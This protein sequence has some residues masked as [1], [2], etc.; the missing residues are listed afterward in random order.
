MY[1]FKPFPWNSAA[2]MDTVGCGRRGCVSFTRLDGAAGPLV[3]VKTLPKARSDTSDVRNREIIVREIS[4]W[5]RASGRPHVCSLFDVL[6]DSAC[7]YLVLEACRG[8]DLAGASLDLVRGRPDG[9]RVAVRQTAMGLAACHAADIFH[10]DVKPANVLLKID[11]REGLYVKLG[12][13][14]ASRAVGNSRDQGAVAEATPAYAA[15][16]IAAGT[17]SAY[18][19]EGLAADVWALGV[20]A[21]ELLGDSIKDPQALDFVRACLEPRP[22]DRPT[23][24]QALRHP[25]LCGE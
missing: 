22:G 15:P 11:P 1:G 5:K 20:L 7:V 2:P 14:G 8:G 19:R 6:E 12:D 17:W 10:G 25:W 13:F 23:S 4:N 18:G 9:V 24:R 16:E 3:A 21:R